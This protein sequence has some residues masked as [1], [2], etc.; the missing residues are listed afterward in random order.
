MKLFVAGLGMWAV[1]G[2]AVV[3]ARVAQWRIR[4]GESL[5]DGAATSPA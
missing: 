2:G 1:L 5:T 4:K 3:A